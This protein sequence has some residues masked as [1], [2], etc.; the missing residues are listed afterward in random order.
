MKNNHLTVASAI[1]W[2]FAQIETKIRNCKNNVCIS[3]KNISVLFAFF[4]KFYSCD[5]AMDIVFYHVCHLIFGQ[6]K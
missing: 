6:H 5:I 4:S 3:I 2:Y 1:K